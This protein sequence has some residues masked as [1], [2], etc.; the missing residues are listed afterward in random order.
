MEDILLLY[1]KW[2]YLKLPESANKNI[3]HLTNCTLPPKW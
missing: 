2:S 1:D 3:S